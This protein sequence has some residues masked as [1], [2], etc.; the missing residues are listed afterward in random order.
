MKPHFLLPFLFLA[1]CSCA[2]KE[3]AQESSS[4]TYSA[5]TTNPREFLDFIQTLPEVKLPYEM[6]C[7]DCCGRG[8]YDSS[9]S[10]IAKYIPK[11]AGLIG[12]VFVN[13]NYVGVLITYSADMIIPSVVIYDVTGRK[14]DQRN[15]MTGWCGSE[16]H[17]ESRQYF[18][19]SES[20]LLTEIDTTF[21]F[22]VD[23]S[24]QR[25]SVSKQEAL[26]EDFVVNRSGKIVHKE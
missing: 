23:D 8:F 9:P 13:E 7:A 14:I 19:I 15:F 3:S 18:Q 22:E 5:A 10:L 4:H 24:V 25:I 16:P 20:L 1:M 11:G 6:N 12:T 26:R 2:S 17:E 21:E